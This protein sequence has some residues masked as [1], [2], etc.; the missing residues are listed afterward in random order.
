MRPFSI[1]GTATAN[2]RDSY[3][4]TIEFHVVAPAEKFDGNNAN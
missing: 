1:V 2:I 3:N 4:Y